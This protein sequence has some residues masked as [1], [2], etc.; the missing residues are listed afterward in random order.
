MLFVV[1]KSSLVILQT[2]VVVLRLVEHVLDC[3][4]CNDNVPYFVI[5]I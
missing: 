1:C 2:S 3:C 4:V 5:S